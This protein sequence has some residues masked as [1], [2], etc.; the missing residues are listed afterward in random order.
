LQRRPSSSSCIRVCMPPAG[1]VIHNPRNILE[2]LSPSLAPRRALIRLAPP[3][4]REAVWRAA[5][6]VCR[7]IVQFSARGCAYVCVISVYVLSKGRR[8]GGGESAICAWTCVNKAADGGDAIEWQTAG[9]VK[10]TMTW[11]ENADRQAGTSL[12]AMATVVRQGRVLCAWWIREDGER[13]R[14]WCTF[15]ARRL[16]DPAT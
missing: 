12:A 2:D 11:R 10:L 4:R 8:A 13:R 5:G 14:R 7:H 6:R 15:Q 3:Q 16:G 9:R 1:R